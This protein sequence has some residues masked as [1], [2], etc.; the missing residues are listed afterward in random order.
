MLNGEAAIGVSVG[1]GS[2]FA[3]ELLSRAGFDFVLVDNQHGRWDDDSSLDA[4]RYIMLG[5]AV[6]MARVSQND[7]YAIG[8]LLDRGALG[9]IVPMVNSVEEARAAAHAVRYPPRGGRSSGA[10]LAVH[11]GADYQSWSDDQVFLAVQIESATAVEQAEAILSVEG[12]DGCW[13]GPNDLARS[14]AVDLWTPPHMDAIMRVLEACQ[15]THKIAGISAEVDVSE[16]V[17]AGFQ[18]VTAANDA[19]LLLEGAKVAWKFLGK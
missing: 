7:Y 11:L 8:R 1:L 3:A 12:V 4:F 15:K 19:K 6:P 18:F 10:L 13:I 2:P 14:M 9:I 17:S 16:W 5:S